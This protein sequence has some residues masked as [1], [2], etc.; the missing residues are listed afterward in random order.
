MTPETEVTATQACEATV[1]HRSWWWCWCE[2]NIQDMLR[3]RDNLVT[4]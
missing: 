3:N 4:N 2:R 1:H